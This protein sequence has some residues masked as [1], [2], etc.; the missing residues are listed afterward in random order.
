M[1]A[2][3]SSRHQIIITKVSSRKDFQMDMDFSEQM[4]TSIS[5]ILSWARN[6]GKESFKPVMA[7]KLNVFSPMA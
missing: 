5:G 2:R 4:N 7:F 3:V 1:T 6:K